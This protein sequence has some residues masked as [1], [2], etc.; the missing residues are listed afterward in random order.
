MT[1]PTRAAIRG[2]SSLLLV[3]QTIFAAP[4][5]L[6]HKS[7]IP[8]LAD[9]ISERTL[10]YVGW[11]GFNALTNQT[12]QLPGMVRRVDEQTS[13][14]LNALLPFIVSYVNSENPRMADQMK[15]LWKLALG[16]RD[17]P[18]GFYFAGMVR[19]KDG[20]PYPRL[21]FISDVQ[22]DADAVVARLKFVNELGRDLNLPIRIRRDGGIVRVTMGQTLPSEKSLAE[23]DAFR[24][25]LSDR[26]SPPAIWV[27]V[28]VGRL[29]EVVEQSALALPRLAKIAAKPWQACKDFSG[30][31]QVKGFLWTAGF[32]QGQWVTRGNLGVC[33]PWHGLP[34]LLKTEAIENVLLRAVPATASMAGAIQVR[35]DVA[36]PIVENVLKRIDPSGARR[37]NQGNALAQ[38]FLKDNP[39]QRLIGALGKQWV[40]YCDR[41]VGGSGVDGLVFANRLRNATQ[42]GNW[43]GPMM[44]LLRADQNSMQNG[45]S[46]YL[47]ETNGL[48]LWRLDFSGVP[49]TLGVCGS[50]LIVSSRL[51]SVV[52]ACEFIQNTSPAYST[53]RDS[54]KSEGG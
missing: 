19:E 16:L 38:V 14:L 53:K 44:Q 8:P 21:G 32:E 51:N 6:G 25:L 29:P 49:L 1:K 35:P 48:N 20:L 34:F 28:N 9:E 54:R 18:T 10:V 4:T 15:G 33:E 40:Y 39:R 52:N 11:S 27:Y 50:Y 36:I 3:T 45:V 30:L 41:D 42:F 24:S 26:E 17:Y 43:L 5:D 2:V 46:A 37:L 47:C 7:P 23:T 22:K 13:D 31:E 12:D